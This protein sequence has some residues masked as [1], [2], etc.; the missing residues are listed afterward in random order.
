MTATAS[1]ALS[2]RA[3]RWAPWAALLV[4]LAVALGIGARSGS[5]DRTPEQRTESIAS[6]V[7]CPVCQGLSVAQSKSGAARAIYEEIDRQVTDGRSDDEVLAYLV[8]RYGDG[9]LLR[10]P[11]NGISG[12]VWAV[13]VVA[14]V[15]GFGALAVAFRRWRPAPVR[16]PSDDDRRL[17]AEA[18]ERSD[19]RRDGRVDGQGDGR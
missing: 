14:L 19:G 16:P 2:R 10:P 5:G 1:T 15:A 4:V 18:L 13:P 12:L 17:V 3:R 6:R 11:A 7:R 9:I 8:S